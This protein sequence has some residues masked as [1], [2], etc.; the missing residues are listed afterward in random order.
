[1]N[2]RQTLKT[3]GLTAIAPLASSGNELEAIGG[4]PAACRLFPFQE[5]ALKAIEE[6]RTSLFIWP[7]GGSK[8]F[9]LSKAIGV[10]KEKIVGRG[11]FMFNGMG[12]FFIDELIPEYFDFL[13]K[14]IKYRSRTVVFTSITEENNQWLLDNMN[15]F[16]YIDWRGYQNIP[17]ALVDKKTLFQKRLKSEDEYMMEIRS[18]FKTG[19]LKYKYPLPSYEL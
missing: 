6:N 14:R 9:T 17:E 4:K 12:P 7:R 11:S 2:R 19:K 13:E 5:N 1:M 10:K 18:A 3:L 16:D 15:R 8:T